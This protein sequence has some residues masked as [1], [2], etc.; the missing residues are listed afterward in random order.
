MFGF[1]VSDVFLLKVF[2]TVKADMLLY[3]KYYYILKV[4]GLE[5]LDSLKSHSK[6]HKDPNRNQ[7]DENNP[8]SSKPK[9]HII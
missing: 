5:D 9:G 6:D 1:L 4:C 7:K 8:S 2:K 3:N